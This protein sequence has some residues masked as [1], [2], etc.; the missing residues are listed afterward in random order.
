MEISG[1]FVTGLKLLLEYYY[2]AENRLPSTFS[3]GDID[4][5]ISSRGHRRLADMLKM[6]SLATHI[7]AAELGIPDLFAADD[8]QLAV[9][10]RW[11]VSFV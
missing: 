2:T 11:R 1:I 4:A 9:R 5:Q 3:S 6:T 7:S 8:R 10:R